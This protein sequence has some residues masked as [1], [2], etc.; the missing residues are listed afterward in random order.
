MRLEVKYARFIKKP[1][2]LPRNEVR[3]GA[4]AAG[5]RFERHVHAA[6]LGRYPEQ[7]LPSP[8]I[9]YR[10][11]HQSRLSFC[12][13]DG[14]Y[15]DIGEG[16]IVIVEVKL[17]HGRR[18]WEQLNEL[19]LPCVSQIFHDFEI[20]LI[21]VVKWFDPNAFRDQKTALCESIHTC[22]PRR[23]K[24]FNVHILR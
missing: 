24:M 3:K 12:Q 18:A 1:D 2:W 11:E 13:P 6:L 20:R 5:M 21:E 17:K 16:L 10:K 8:W 4:K 7:Y 14:L 15:I 22:S 9:G 23:A 19:Y